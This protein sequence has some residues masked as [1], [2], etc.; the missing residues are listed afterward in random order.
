LVF[1]GLHGVSQL[2]DNLTDFFALWAFKGADIKSQAAGCNPRQHSWGFAF[3]AWWSVKLAHDVVPHIWREHNTLSHRVGAVT[4][5]VMDR[6]CALQYG[7]A[8]LFC[9]PS[10]KK[11]TI[12]SRI[13]LV[14]D[15]I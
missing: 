6:R 4:R 3:R 15:S 12:G 10:K 13:G 5:P 8:V 2:G 11:L 14:P 1:S 9:S 7:I